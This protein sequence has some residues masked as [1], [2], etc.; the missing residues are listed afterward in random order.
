MKKYFY[1][2]KKAILSLQFWAT[3]RKPLNMTVTFNPNKYWG[4]GVKPSGLELYHHGKNLTENELLDSSDKYLI[5]QF[6]KGFLE[7]NPTK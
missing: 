7:N 3:P 5:Y 4:N 1:P 2:K 6:C